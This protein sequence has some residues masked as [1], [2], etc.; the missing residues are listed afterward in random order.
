MLAPPSPAC[1]PAFDQP[2]PSFAARRP[3]CLL[4]R[5]VALLAVTM[6]L[7][8]PAHANGVDSRVYTCAGLQQLIAAHGFVFISQATFGDFVVANGS[9]CDGGSVTQLR[10]VPTSDTPGCPVNYC[11]PAHGMGLGGGG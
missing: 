10:T 9:Y 3:P 8:C 1:A 11:E 6:L 5:H 7:A 4:A 2:A